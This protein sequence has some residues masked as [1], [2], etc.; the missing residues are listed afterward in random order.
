MNSG[1]SEDYYCRPV[2]FE[3]GDTDVSD[4]ETIRPRGVTLSGTVILD[5]DVPRDIL[6]RAKLS[7]RPKG[8]SKVG[9]LPGSLQ[10]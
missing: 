8:I 10:H 5:E 6:L 4:L 3:I 2:Y 7:F 1:V 9:Q